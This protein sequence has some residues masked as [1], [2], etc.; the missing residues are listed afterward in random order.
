MAAAGSIPHP[1]PSGTVPTAADREGA[2]LD[3]DDV[4]VRFGGLVALAGVSLTV[5]PGETMGMIGPNGSGKTTLFNAIV[6]LYPVASGRI[7]LD[8]TDITGHPTHHIARLGVAR[9]FQQNRVLGGQSVLDNMLLG[10]PGL[11]DDAACAW[12]A[13]FNPDLLRRLDDPACDLPLIDRRRVEIAR[14]LVAAPRLLLLDEPTAG[15]NPEETATMVG[16]IRGIRDALPGL[17]L[18]VIEH[19]MSVISGLCQRV[20]AL[21]N[22]RVLVTGA[23]QAVAADPR[24]LEAYLGVAEAPR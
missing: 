16:E 3:V 13:R 23:F 15:L 5:E 20:V 10:R 22:G 18:V 8:R 1:L 19:D 21:S 2:R 24:V 7:R 9:T 6:G 4:A 12:L 11:S 17:T 14:A